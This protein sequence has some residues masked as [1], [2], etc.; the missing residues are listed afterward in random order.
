VT[1]F[2]NG[3]VEKAVEGEERV[4]VPSPRDVPTYD[5]KPEMSAYAVTDQLVERLQLDVFDFVVV[6]YANADMVGHTGVIGAAVAA[7]EAVDECLG[8][9]TAAAAARGGVCLITAD[10][11]NA[12]VMLEPSGS[13]NTAHSTNHVPFIATLTGARARDDGR[14]SDLAPT[15]L[16]L[17]GISKPHEMTGV[18]LL[19][20]AP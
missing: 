17:M 19:D 1:F 15:V 2:F 16:A 4:L 10:H 18:C 20:R 3:G 5:H 14:L 8:R 12:D 7:V 6:N 11:G 13:A 9:V